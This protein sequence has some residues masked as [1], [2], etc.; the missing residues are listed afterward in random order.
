[1]K[2]PNSTCNKSSLAQAPSKE[3]AIRQ[4]IRIAHRLWPNLSPVAIRSLSELLHS[5][6]L[7]VASGDVLYLGDRW[8][9]THTGLL[10]LASKNHCS[11]IDVRPVTKFCDP[12][13]NRWAFKATVYTSRTCR[14]FVGYGDADPCNVSLQVRGAEM[15][16][17]ETRAVNRALRKAYGVGVCSV[18]ELGSS[19]GPLLPAGR[20]RK[21]VP[22]AKPVN[23]NRHHPFRD[24][25]CLLIRQ[26]H[27]DPALVKAYAADYCDL[28]E[29]RQASRDQIA[30]FIKH[31]TE[32]AQKD[33]EN[34]VCQL[35]SYVAKPVASVERT[36]GDAGEPKVPGAA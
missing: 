34:L 31:L 29:L 24:R 4:Q 3:N 12:A 25:L 32:Y 11:G 36:P 14:G 5:S 15:G 20:M 35:N 30:T 9:V 22:A 7:C 33:R 13:A 18:E 2:E 21:P 10:H 1:M 26:H 27:L 28:P 19:S 8:Y 6:A 23:G 17:A 16:I